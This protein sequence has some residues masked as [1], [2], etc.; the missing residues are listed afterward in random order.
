MLFS[1]WTLPSS[2]A[3][4]S[5]RQEPNRTNRIAAYDQTC[6]ISHYAATFI[7]LTSAAS[8]VNPFRTVPPVHR[9]KTQALPDRRC[10]GFNLTAQS[11]GHS[12]GCPYHSV[13]VTAI[14]HVI[15]SSEYFYV[16]QAN[17]AAKLRRYISV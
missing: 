16:P 4:T 12:S 10:S 7:I 15:K 14:R 6:I 1:H 11:P 8:F 2:S 9:C 3:E 17:L 5:D 13:V